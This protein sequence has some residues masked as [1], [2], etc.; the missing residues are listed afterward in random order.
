M[1]RKIGGLDEAFTIP[2]GRG[3]EAVR[4]GGAGTDSRDTNALRHAAR[5]ILI[6]DL[7]IDTIT[8][9]SRNFH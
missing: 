7:H 8:V 3:D 5:D 6:P 9:K 2:S 1:L 4:G